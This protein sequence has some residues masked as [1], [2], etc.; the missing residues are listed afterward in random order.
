MA[1]VSLTLLALL[2]AGDHVVDA[3]RDQ[4]TLSRVDDQLGRI[5]IGATLAA[6]NRPTDLI[7]D[8]GQALDR[9]GGPDPSPHGP[10]TGATANRRHHRTEL[11]R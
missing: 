2:P 4:D 8:H 3:G 11:T 9:L 6:A 5:G 1:A 10:L 7:A